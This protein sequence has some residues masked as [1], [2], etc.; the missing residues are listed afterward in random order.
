MTKCN[1][2]RITLILQENLTSFRIKRKPFSDRYLETFENDEALL[3]GAGR[4]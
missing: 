4:G 1:P 2:N 3:E